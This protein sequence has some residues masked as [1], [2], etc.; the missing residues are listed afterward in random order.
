MRRAGSF[1]LSDSGAAPR[2]RASVDLLSAAPAERRGGRREEPAPGR[3]AEKPGRGGKQPPRSRSR[4]ALDDQ[5][6]RLEPGQQ[7]QRWRGT[8]AG[9]DRYQQ[10]AERRMEAWLAERVAARG[11]AEPARGARAAEP[12][13]PRERAEGQAEGAR[14]RFEYPLPQPRGF[15]ARGHRNAGMYS[16][17]EVRIPSPDYSQ[18]TMST[19][20]KLNISNR[21]MDLPSALY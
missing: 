5:R 13:A 11:R 12:V 3:V 1:Q 18:T 8:E 10:A 4:D 7:Q 21:I 6:D 15:L 14:G 20:V 17:S 16:E 19:V 2:R 9:P